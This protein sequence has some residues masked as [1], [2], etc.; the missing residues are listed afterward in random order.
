M[1][2][3]KPCRIA[4]ASWH[5]LP[6]HGTKALTA[7][8]VSRRK[9]GPVH[10]YVLPRVLPQFFGGRFEG[11]GDAFHF[12]G[13][14][15]PARSRARMKAAAPRL[16]EEFEE[17]ARPGVASTGCTRWMQRGG[18]AAQVGMLRVCPLA[19]STVRGS[20]KCDISSDP[21]QIRPSDFADV[22][23][24]HVRTVISRH[25]VLQKTMVSASHRPKALV[26]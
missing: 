23:R 21:R 9:D 8:N 6:P 25:A 18:D 2:P 11:L 20:S 16:I 26:N 7:R 14:T 17:L 15:L 5:A 4:P 10:T 3:R 24:L 1:E 19:A 12:A 22:A 13:S